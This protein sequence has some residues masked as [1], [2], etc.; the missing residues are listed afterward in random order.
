[1]KH[2][3]TNLKKS[4]LTALMLCC[5]LQVAWADGWKLTGTKVNGAGGRWENNQKTRIDCSYKKGVFNYERKV[6]NGTKM[7]ALRSPSASFMACP[8]TSP[9]SSTV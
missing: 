9:T 2:M 8:S 4:L 7:D 6:T 1:M 3:K 5:A